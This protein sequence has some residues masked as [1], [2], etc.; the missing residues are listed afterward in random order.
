MITVY[1][2]K[3]EALDEDGRVQFTMEAIDEH[4][5]KVDI[6]TIIGPDNIDE[7]TDAMRRAVVM[8]ELK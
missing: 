3:I 5:A 4:A 8:L 1:P 2:V 7:L 6:N